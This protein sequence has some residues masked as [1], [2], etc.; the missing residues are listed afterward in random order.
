MDNFSKNPFGLFFLEKKSLN[1]MVTGACTGSCLF[2]QKIPFYRYVGELSGNPGVTLP[3]PAMNV[4][5]GGRHSGNGLAMQ[6]FMIL[7][8]GTALLAVLYTCIMVLLSLV[9]TIENWFLCVFS[10]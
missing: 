1:E 5:N 6:E 7:P 4:I 10:P 9:I 3:V 8:T 2:F